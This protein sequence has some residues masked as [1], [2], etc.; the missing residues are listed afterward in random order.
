MAIVYNGTTVSNAGIS[1]NGGTVNEVWVCDTSNATCTKVYPDV[2][3]LTIC[4]RGVIN[5]LV[6]P[7]N[8]DGVYTYVC[9]HGTICVDQ[10]MGWSI[11]TITDACSDGRTNDNFDMG[12]CIIANQVAPDNID[13]KVTYSCYFDY[14]V[15]FYADHAW[16]PDASSPY[17]C[18]CW[19]LL[20]CNSYEFT[21]SNVTSCCCNIDTTNPLLL[22]S[23]IYNYCNGE[24]A[25]IAGRAGC[26]TCQRGFASCLSNFRRTVEIY[27]NGVRVVCCETPA[28]QQVTLCY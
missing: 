9:P 10:G 18:T 7:P 2:N 5:E 15:Y 19:P 20:A 3:C 28:N 22:K 17:E 4:N 14:P 8:S 21:Y 26:R 24:T 16:S 11:Y 6:S 25:P 12:L 27:R 1:Y 23:G 13:V